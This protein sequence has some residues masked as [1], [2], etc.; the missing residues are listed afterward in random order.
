[1]RK[2]KYMDRF[3]K[4]DVMNLKYRSRCKCGHSV[5]NA[6][7]FKKEY[8]ICNWCG[9]RIYKDPKKQ[10]EY[11]KR[12]AKNEFAYELRKSIDELHDREIRKMNENKKRKRTPQIHTKRFK[13]NNSYFDFLSKHDVNVITVEFGDNGYIRIQFHKKQGRPKKKKENNLQYKFKI[14]NNRSKFF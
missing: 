14:K 9:S 6:P 1:M 2:N 5:C 10:D 4:L 12:T 13:D 3:H 7:G 8:I 11:D